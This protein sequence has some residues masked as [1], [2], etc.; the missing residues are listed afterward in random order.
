MATYILLSTLTLEGTDNLKTHPALI[1]ETNARLASYGIKVV[2][3]YAVLGPYD[4]V[5]IV[6]AP[7]NATVV[8]ASAA[9]S[10]SGNVRLTTLPAVAVEDFLA[11]LR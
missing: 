7:D 1:D 9:L 2:T 5:T 10:L 3:Q 6:E 4:F 11:S 8:R